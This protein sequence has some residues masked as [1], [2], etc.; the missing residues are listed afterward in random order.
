[1]IQGRADL[2]TLARGDTS[3]VDTR[4]VQFSTVASAAW[5]IALED[6]FDDGARFLVSG[7]TTN[8]GIEEVP[9]SGEGDEP[10]ATGDDSR[11]GNTG[12]SV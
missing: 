7:A 6:S 5:A 11:K 3:P 10:D 9:Q 12:R 4:P 2:L 8:V 1:V